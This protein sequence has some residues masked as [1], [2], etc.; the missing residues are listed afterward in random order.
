MATIQIIES[1]SKIIQIS[2]WLKE[3]VLLN[4]HIEVAV[5]RLV[6]KLFHSFS[7]ATENALFPQV[8]NKKTSIP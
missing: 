2:Y 3:G 7:A 8:I 1:N 4:E 6:S 5:F